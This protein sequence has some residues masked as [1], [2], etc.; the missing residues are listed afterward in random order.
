MLYLHTYINTYLTSTTTVQTVTFHEIKNTNVWCH[1]YTILNCMPGSLWYT[2]KMLLWSYICR[3]YCLIKFHEL[4]IRVQ[5]NNSRN[6]INNINLESNQLNWIINK[7]CQVN[8]LLQHFLFNF[9]YFII[10]NLWKYFLRLTH[11]VLYFARLFGGE[12]HTIL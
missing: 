3:K 7:Y 8:I 11:F 4:K 5:L 10:L 2:M 12:I 1:C 6:S 9:L